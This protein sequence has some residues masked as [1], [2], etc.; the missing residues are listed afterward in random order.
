LEQFK[1]EIESKKKFTCAESF[2][3]KGMNGSLMCYETAQELG[4]IKI[5]VN[6]ITQSSQI[7]DEFADRFSG[8]GKLK[9]FPVN[10]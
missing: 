10:F 9:G 4:L 3:V 5:Q 7:L 6:T 1:G 8:I 2:V